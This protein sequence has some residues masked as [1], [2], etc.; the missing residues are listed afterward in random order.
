MDENMTTQ[1][2]ERQKPLLTHQPCPDCGSSDALSVYEDHTFCFSCKQHTWTKPLDYNPEVIVQHPKSGRPT[3]SVQK[4]VSRRIDHLGTLK[5]YEVETTSDGLSLFHYFSSAGVWKGTKTRKPDDK[6]TIRWVGDGSEP[7]L[8]GQFVQKPTAKKALVITEGEYD[9]LVVATNLPLDKYHVVSLPG[10]ASSVGHVL[11]RHWDYLHGWSEVILAGDTDGPGKDATDQ[12][13]TALGTAMDAMPVS[14]V[15]WPDECKDAC[16]VHEKGLSVSDFVAGAT[17]WR[18][19]NI[20]DMHDLIPSLEKPVDYGLPI[21]FERLSERLGGYRNN[22]MWTIVAGTGVGKSTLVGHLC[23]DLKVTHGKRVGLMF[24]EERSEHAL[25]R[26]LSIHLKT[27]LLRPN[28]AFSVSEQV[29]AAK[30]LFE[31]DTFY[32]YDHFGSV[33]NED[34]L[35]RMTYLANGVNCDYIILDHITI[36]STLPMSGGGVLSERQSID[37]LTTAIR[38]Q[39]VDACGVSVILVSHTRKPTH[40]DHSDGSAQVRLSDIRGTGA[41]AQLSDA[42]IAIDKSK[43][44][45]GDV[46]RGAVDLTVLKNRMSG[47]VGSAGTLL[48]DDIQGR[49][50]CSSAL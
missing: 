48:Y 39:I 26:L 29:A 37:A 33:S 17:R 20:H 8:F 11:H 22:E 13:A 19:E 47:D 5:R 23:I 43:D 16:D 42:V 40:G 50:R 41:I 9:C 24:L 30:E 36:A 6:D 49:L 31:P 28:S 1:H 46:V 45:A 44:E 3:G 4:I 25:R 18:P 34:L 15:K 32:T 27:N 12:L 14:V 21:M 38:T 10:G 7:A 2:D 35:R